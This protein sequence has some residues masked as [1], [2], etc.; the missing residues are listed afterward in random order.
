VAGVDPPVA[1]GRLPGRRV[2]RRGPDEPGA[3]HTQVAAV[4]PADEVA[5]AGRN[6]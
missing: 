5:G 1:Q 3:R 6:S 4:G 2:E